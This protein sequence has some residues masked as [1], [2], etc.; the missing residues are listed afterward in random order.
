MW[1]LEFTWRHP[2]DNYVSSGGVKL[3]ATNKRSAFAEAKRKWTKAKKEWP[4]TQGPSLVFRIDLP[5]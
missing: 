1:Y 3:K 4:N 5:D 2:D